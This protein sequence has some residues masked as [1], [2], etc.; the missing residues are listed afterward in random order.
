VTTYQPTRSRGMPVTIGELALVAIAVALWLA[1]IF[2][3]NLS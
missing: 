1:L 3:W 2:G